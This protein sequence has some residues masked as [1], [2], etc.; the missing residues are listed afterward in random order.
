M[1]WSEPDT[2]YH[3]FACPA[4][5]SPS[6]YTQWTALLYWWLFESL[7]A[8][9]PWL[10]LQMALRPCTTILRQSPTRTFANLQI[11]KMLPSTEILLCSFSATIFLVSIATRLF[12]SK[13]GWWWLSFGLVNVYEHTCKWQQ[14]TEVTFSR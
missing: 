2:I 4:Y 13:R 12:C 3:G 7:L 1:V 6:Y 14:M 11:E 10:A 9:V 5:H 8:C